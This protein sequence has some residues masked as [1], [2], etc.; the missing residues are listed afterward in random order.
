MK[1]LFLIPAKY[2][3]FNVV[4]NSDE[5]QAF[6]IGTRF[7]NPITDWRL[8][9]FVL[10]AMP[11]PKKVPFVLGYCNHATEDQIAQLPLGLRDE[12]F[13]LIKKS[14]I[15]KHQVPVLLKLATSQSKS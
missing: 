11:T 13:Q 2:G 14:A 7:A 3:L 9:E 6:A 12:L 10:P 1:S 5:Q 15:A 8:V 4:L